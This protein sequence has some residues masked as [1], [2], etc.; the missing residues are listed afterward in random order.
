VSSTVDLEAIEGPSV[1]RRPR[2]S[3][4]V[5][6]KNEAAN[7]PYVLCRM[8]QCVDE[9]ILVDGSSTDETVAVAVEMRPEIVVVRQAGLGKGGGLACGFAAA[10]GDIIVTIDADG[11]MDPAEIPALVETMAVRGA[12]YAKGSRLLDG[13]GSDDLTRTRRLGNWA[14]RS[15]VNT[16]YGTQYTDLCYGLNA[17]W[18]V[19]LPVLG[20]AP[21][22][23]VPD[24]LGSGFE[25]ETCLNIRAARAD[26][27]VVEVPSYEKVRL[28]GVSNLR[29]IRDGL[30]V[31]RTIFHELRQPIGRQATE[32]SGLE[33]AFRSDFSSLR[34]V[35]ENEDQVSNLNVAM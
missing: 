34:R 6:A 32:W 11:S 9:V 12:D 29:V 4:V 1:V 25:I 5:P 31:L 13:G 26:L 24:G 15:L 18:R 19:H 2:V 35:E 22:S 16:I 10:T 23:T 30:R 27:T 14:L 7:L 3:V 8:P 28:S 33:E 17:F 20:F 21:G